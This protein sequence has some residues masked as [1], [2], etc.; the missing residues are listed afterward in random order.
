MGQDVNELWFTRCPVPTATGIAADL[1]WFGDEFGP[2]GIKVKSLQDVPRS[3]LSG[4]HFEH[5]L[6]ALFREG[7]NVPALVDALRGQQTR[8][9]GLTWIEERQAILVRADSDLDSVTDLKGRRLALPLRDRGTVDFWRAMALH[10][11][12][13]ALS[14]EG[15]TTADAVLV[16]I[17]SSWGEGGTG[18]LPQQWDPELQALVADKVDAVYVKGAVGVEAGEKAG[19]RVLLD[20]D[21]YPDRRARVNNG[22]PRPITVHQRLLDERPDLVARFLSVL[23]KA[24]DWAAEHPS[25]LTAILEGETGAGHAGVAGAYR[26]DFHLT[27]I[28]TCRMSA[29]NCS[30]SRRTFSCATASSSQTSSLRTGPTNRRSK[31]PDVSWPQALSPKRGTRATIRRGREGIVPNVSPAKQPSPPVTRESL[32]EAAGWESHEVTTQLRLGTLVL[33]APFGNP[34]ILAKEIATLNLL[35]DGRFEPESGPVGRRRVP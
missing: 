5:G 31:R 2:D 19:T 3:N 16:D 9:I 6:D 20:L 4:Q 7:G 8:L 23:L 18:N 11:F 24:A 22:T 27:S 14:T 10:G 32:L 13:G 1:G 33:A 21:A 35:S 34:A 29:C 30:S 12:T 17:A 28:R 15:L 26:S 25:D